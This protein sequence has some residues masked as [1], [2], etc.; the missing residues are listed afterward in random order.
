VARLERKPAERV[1]TAGLIV[2]AVCGLV[3][4]VFAKLSDAATVYVL[5]WQTMIGLLPWLACLMHLRQSRLAEEETGEWERLRAERAAGGARGELFEADEIQAFAARSRLRILEKYLS[6][7]LSAILVLL[8]GAGIL[9]TLWT[10]AISLS[11]VNRD[12][13]LVS[14]ASLCAVTFAL[15]LIATYASGMSRQA[16][17]RPLRAGAGFMMF[18]TLL[19]GASAVALALGQF[20][21]SRP[22]RIMAYI[23][24]GLMGIV[25]VEML[26]TFVLDFYRPRV[27]GV[28]ARPGYD[29][30]LL[31]LLTQPSGLFKTV[32]ATLDYQFGFRVS[33]TWFYRFIEQ[34]IAPLI[35]FQILTLYALTCFVI[36]GSEQQGVVERFGKFTKVI[37]PGLT[38][39]WPWPIE[40]AYRFSAN[41]VKTLVL[42]HTGE[43][44]AGEKLLWT[45]KHYETE[46]DVMVATRK[47]TVEKR[48]VPAV[49]LIVA[50]STVRYRIDD[51]V[52]W[53]YGC[54]KPEHLLE[55]L[56]NREMMQHLAAVDFFDVMGPGRARA[57]AHLRRVMQDAADKVESA[58]GKGLGVKILGVGL[59]G[60]HPPITEGL[61]EAFH[62]KVVARVQK[63]VDRLEAE[64]SEIEVVI[65]AKSDAEGVLFEAQGDYSASVFEAEAAAKRFQVQNAAYRDAE[66]VF[67]AREYLSAL[68]DALKGVRLY[69]LSVKGLDREHVRLNLEDPV[70]L[71][72]EDIAPFEKPIMPEDEE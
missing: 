32:A 21:F 64:R 68:E 34:A 26:L 10:D 1:A 40:R 18:S 33:Q 5:A 28:E 27:E 49:N 30:R 54:S 8:L 66:Q 19:C 58:A 20:G 23:M 47:S 62:E 31:G 3:V 15:F 60:I 9:V 72:V 52:K 61:P 57:S 22:D 11:Q 16:E 50:S 69:V 14:F 41:E 55:S 70:R 36:V 38:V 46:Y 24:L 65:N 13:A 37:E 67:R 17:W 59:E 6:P 71:D 56:C 2:Q 29:S 44:K 39:K 51:P 53:Y 63:E 45:E 25:A 42:G 35:L 48:D 12:R 43:L 7:T 4:I